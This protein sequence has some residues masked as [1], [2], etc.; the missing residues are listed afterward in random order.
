M[1]IIVI[2]LVLNNLLYVYNMIF[3]HGKTKE[4]GM[5]DDKGLQRRDAIFNEGIK[6]KYL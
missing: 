6:K 2:L 4:I 5:M 3:T 1:E